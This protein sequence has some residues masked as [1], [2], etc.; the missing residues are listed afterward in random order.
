MKHTI[1]FALTVLIFS[2]A[3][4]KA[5]CQNRGGGWQGYNRFAGGF[6]PMSQFSMPF[7]GGMS[8]QSSGSFGWP[9]FGGQ[10]FGGLNLGGRGMTGFG[11]QGFG[12]Q[13]MGIMNGFGQGQMS[14]GGIGIRGQG[15]FQTFGQGSLGGLG[16]NN[17][18]NFNNIRGNFR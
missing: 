17:R 3:P 6:N 14:F 12:A 18:M 16:T 1:I 13:G 8:V 11:P 15:G 4:N 10:G 7:Q 2:A 9:G 5:D